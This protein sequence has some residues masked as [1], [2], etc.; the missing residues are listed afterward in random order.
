M[1]TSAA[2]GPFNIDAKLN[3]AYNVMGLLY[4]RAIL[5]TV[6]IGTRCARTRTAI[7]ALR[8]RSSAEMNGFARFRSSGGAVIEAIADSQF[9][10]TDYTFRPVVDRSLAYA[11]QLIVDNADASKDPRRRQ[12]QR[13]GRRRW[14]SLFPPRF[15]SWHRRRRYDRLLWDGPWQ[16]QEDAGKLQARSTDPPAPRWPFVFTGN[17]IV[18]TGDWLKD[19]AR[20][21]SIWTACRTASSNP[22]FLAGEEKKKT[23]FFGPHES[24]AGRA[25]RHADGEWKE[26]TRVLGT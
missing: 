13:R 8:R 20:R 1:W 2:S 3:G 10:F 25:H 11:E 15:R 6:E 23:A 26:K 21:R 4:G 16:N 24:A 18:I 7:P 19:G 14:R 22:L 12:A 5:K 9:I 17:G